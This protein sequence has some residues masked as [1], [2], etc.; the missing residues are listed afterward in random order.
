MTPADYPDRAGRLNNFSI[1]LIT[2]YESEG[3]L[4][5]LAQA[6]KHSQEALDL[7][8]TSNPERAELLYTLSKNLNTRYIRE[9]RLEDLDQAI[10]CS[11][12]AV[13][14]TSTS[15]PK[16][17]AFL[18][19]LGYHLSTRY[20]SEERLED[21]TQAIEHRQSATNCLNSPPSTRIS[22]CLEAIYRL[23]QLQRWQEARALLGRGL[24]ILPLLISNLSLKLDQEHIMKSISG[25]AAIGCS[26]SLECSDD[27]FEAIRV[28]ELTRGTINRLATYLTAERS[29]LYC[30]DPH[31]A[32]QFEDLRS[33]I[34]V[35]SEDKEDLRKTTLS[36][37]PATASLHDSVAYAPS[38]IGFESFLDLPSK[39]EL[40]ENSFDQATVF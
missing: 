6:I 17:G 27:V 32:E 13:N 20:E 3:R 39:V 11:Q 30:S 12:E 22:G 15:N 37:E 29:M 40:L 16:R 21:L 25:L 24:E 14:L 38:D 8:S 28:L 26:V 4:E 18:N 2:R 23:T 10:K 7:I 9:K 31:L 1:Y 5:D 34:N 35:L 36:R 33:L 19:R